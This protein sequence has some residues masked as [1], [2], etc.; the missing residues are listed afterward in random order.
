MVKNVRRKHARTITGLVRRDTQCVDAAL[1]VEALAAYLL[2]SDVSSVAVT[3]AGKLIG[4]VS[5]TDLLRAHYGVRRDEAK[6]AFSLGFH[7]TRIVRTRVGEIMTPFPFALREDATVDQAVALMT[8]EGLQQIPVLDDHGRFVGMIS[9]LDI[10]ACLDRDEDAAPL[11]DG[12]SEIRSIE[13]AKPSG[14]Q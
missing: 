2:E 5:T 4:I 9:S 6:P 14:P 1:S 10:I 13:L 8:F 3:A 11:H 12:W 7:A